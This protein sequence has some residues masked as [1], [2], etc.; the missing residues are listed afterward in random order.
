M[1]KEKISISIS[2]AS[3]NFDQPLSHVCA[4]GS[5]I[6]LDYYVIYRW[7]TNCITLNFLSGSKSQVRKIRCENNF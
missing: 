2:S 6:N 1:C 7:Q 3:N 4:K 5:R